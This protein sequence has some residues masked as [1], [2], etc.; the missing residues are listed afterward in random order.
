MSDL[1]DYL[2]CWVFPN[3]FMVTM[4]STEQWR[5]VKQKNGD[6]Y[7]LLPQNIDLL[8]VSSWKKKP[9]FSIKYIYIERGKNW[10]TQYFCE[11]RFKVKTNT[12]EHNYFLNPD[13]RLKPTYVNTIFS[14]LKPRFSYKSTSV[15]IY[16]L[17]QFLSSPIFPLYI[18]LN[19]KGGETKFPKL[20]ACI[21][22]Y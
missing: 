4:L 8:N 18:L 14:D 12:R 13:S 20:N 19:T 6:E 10:Y 17:H 15:N 5:G 16:H 2:D 21:F 7:I 22:F 9:F 3:I 1:F 11:S